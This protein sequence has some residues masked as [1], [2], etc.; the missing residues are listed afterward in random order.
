MNDKTST[1]EHLLQE[2]NEIKKK[3]RNLPVLMIEVFK[4]MALHHQSRRIS[5]YFVKIPIS[6]TFK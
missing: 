1:F 5:I 3:Q 2:N 6:G 4:I